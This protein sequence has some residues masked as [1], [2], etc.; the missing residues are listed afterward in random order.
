MAELAA[1]HMKNKAYRRKIEDA[2]SK[3][4]TAVEK[5][6]KKYIPAPVIACVNE[7]FTYFGYGTGVSIT[8]VI[9]KEN[10]CMM[11]PASIGGHISFKV[12]QACT[13]IKVDNDDYEKLKKLDQERKRLERERDEFGSQVCEA[14]LALRTERAVE[15]ELPEALKYIAFPEVKAVPMPIYKSLRDIIG[16]IEED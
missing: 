4:N 8:T 16:K 10:G 1:C 15:K 14:L 9:V 12:P 11:S 5:L 13:Y 7:F 2:E 3:V 6:V